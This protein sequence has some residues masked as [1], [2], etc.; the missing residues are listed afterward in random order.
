[1]ILLPREHGAYGQLAFPLVTALAVAGVSTT[2]LLLTAS[3]VAG[4]LAHEPA[5]V[6]LG[7]RGSRSGRALRRRAIVSLGVTGAIAAAAGLWAVL[8]MAPAARWSIGVPLVPAAMLLLLTTSG[9]EKTTPGEIAAALAFSGAAVPVV[10][11]CGGGLT[12]ALAVAVPFAFL[13]AASTLAVRVVILGTRGGG[14]PEATATTRRAALG[15]AVGGALLL[16]L[17]H[18][19]GLT[20]ASVLPAAAPGLLTA[21]LVALQP[22]HATRL[23]TLGWTL[24]AVSLLTS[25]I[26]VATR[27]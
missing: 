3:V 22:P 7:L 2:G 19:A 14:D 18:V 1:M 25:V 16:A 12:T 24:I 9:R 6:L 27:S 5:V 10:L 21:T 11:A 13:F 26:I 15:V 8:E 23:R 4:F 20:P 17:S